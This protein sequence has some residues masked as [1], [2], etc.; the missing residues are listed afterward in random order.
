MAAGHDM[1][2]A[3][4][5]RDL[6]HGERERRVDVAEQ[7]VDLVALDQLARLLH[8]R[9]GV[10]A[11]R[12]LDD[13]LAW[14]TEDAAL[15]VDLLE[16]HLA[17]DQFVLS[18]R[19]VS[20]CQRIVEPDAYGVRGASANDEGAGDLGGGEYKAG[21]DEAAAIHA[22]VR[23]EL[24]TVRLPFL[25]QAFADTVVLRRTVAFLDGEQCR[26]PP[27]CSQAAA[28]FQEQYDGRRR[29]RSESGRLLLSMAGP[30]GSAVSRF[31]RPSGRLHDWIALG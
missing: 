11:G 31:D 29:E 23:S 18:R 19:G 6:G 4:L 22:D 3:L 12:I 26:P 10:A 30:I 9:A 28:R 7:E 13:Q 24:G 8:G 5:V 14:A 15:G 2:D 27:G 21:F 16:R 17:A 1:Q 25:R 20:P